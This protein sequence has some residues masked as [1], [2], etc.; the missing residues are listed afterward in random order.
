M[1]L[2]DCIISCPYV[3][4]CL[5]LLLQRLSLFSLISFLFLLCFCLHWFGLSWHIIIGHLCRLVLSNGM[6]NYQYL[7]FV[8]TNLPNRRLKPIQTGYYTI[9]VPDATTGYLRYLTT[10]YRADD[11]GFKVI[12]SECLSHVRKCN[13]QQLTVQNPQ[14]T[15]HYFQRSWA[16]IIR[17]TFTKPANNVKSPIEVTYRSNFRPGT[18]LK[19]GCRRITINMWRRSL[20]RN[21][22]GPVQVLQKEN[23]RLIL[24]LNIINT[25]RQ[26]NI[27]HWTVFDLVSIEIHE[28]IKFNSKI[29][30]EQLLSF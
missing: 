10:H 8:P 19:T 24:K 4:Q 18:G 25:R 16:P 21:K 2:R 12:K 17:L 9:P 20:M 3:V 27:N 23:Q 15:T 30:F 26:I 14:I 1:D 13:V 29:K 22:T 6:I 11:D 7:E 28:S 5:S